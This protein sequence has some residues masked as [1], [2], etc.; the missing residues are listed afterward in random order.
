VTGYGYN[1]ND[2]MTDLTYPS[3]MVIHYTADSENRVTSVRDPSSG[4]YY[5]SSIQYHPTGAL[6]S[7][8]AGNGITHSIA[9]ND[10]NFVSSVNSG[11]ALGLSYTYDNVGN[12]MGITDA[13][14]GMSQTFGY[15]N[16]HRLTSGSG[17]WGQVSY[18]YDAIGNRTAKTFNGS[19]SSYSY[20]PS[21]NRLSSISGADAD[22]LILFD[23]NGNMTRDKNGAYSYVSTNM[24]SRATVSGIQY[25]YYYDGDGQRVRKTSNGASTY[26]Q[27][28]TG[29]K[30]LSEIQ[31]SGP[32]PMGNGNYYYHLDAL[33]SVRALTDQWGQVVE[34]HDFMPFGEEQNAPVTTNPLKFT[35]KERDIETG[36][37]YFGA[38]YYTSLQGRF[39]SADPEKTG[40]M[41]LRDPQQWNL[42]SYTRN[43]PLRFVD[44]DG[45]ELWPI[46]VYTTGGRMQV[47]YI[48][49]QLV[50]RL[51]YAVAYARE[52]GLT[53]TF[54]E[55]FRTQT[56]QSKIRTSNTK[57]TKGTSPH[58]AGLAVD[59]NVSSSLRPNGLKSLHDLTTALG[60]VSVG[61]SP[62][63]N[64]SADLP[65]FQAND[66]ITRDKYGK[67]D[68]AYLDRIQE[69]QHSYVSWE[70]LRKE[71]PNVFNSLVIPIDS[72]TINKKENGK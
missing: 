45:R 6:T 19:G 9:Y 32:N 51:Q 65:H 35:G 36:L 1:A 20:S 54:N 17:S 34:N 16:L 52:K 7:Y 59:I 57:N 71:S 69:N 47:R 66:L 24:M 28:G 44:P 64:Q 5:A 63:S 37:D 13:R 46:S 50:V 27:R 22:S 39:T 60:E 49:A 4:V 68:Q 12:V 41:K 31:D 2:F 61:L 55:L 8:I 67:V 33:G 58:A 48:D 14:P 38:R 29:G 40:S 21:T 25:D 43:N 72:Y 15:D 42:Y 23:G 56:Q 70:T 26:Y 3:G 11:G 10:R 30:L 53:F 62:L 18:G